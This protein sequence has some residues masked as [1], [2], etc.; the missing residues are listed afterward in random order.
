MWHDRSAGEFSE[1]VDTLES[2]GYRVD[3]GQDSATVYDGS[4][5][6]AHMQCD[7]GKLTLIG[8]DGSDLDDILAPADYDLPLRFANETGLAGYFFIRDAPHD[9]GVYA[10]ATYEDGSLRR[11][12]VRS[13]EKVNKVLAFCRARNKDTP[14]ADHPSAI[15]TNSDF[16][17]LQRLGRKNCFIS[18]NKFLDKKSKPAQSK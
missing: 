9:V 14:R 10:L 4:R 13:E 6:V 7:D 16:R 3:A 1:V 8:H 12:Y 11:V 18:I 2:A 17:S 15:L 5:R